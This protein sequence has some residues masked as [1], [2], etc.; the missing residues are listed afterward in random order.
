MWQRLGRDR[1]VASSRI[2]IPLL[3]QVITALSAST[4]VVDLFSGTS[5]VGHALKSDG[6]LVHANDLNAYAATIARAYVREDHLAQTTDH[7]QTINGLQGRPGYFTETFRERSRFFMP[8][9]GARIDA[10]RDWIADGAFEPE[11]EAILL[12]ALME[13]ADR[14][15]STTGVQMASLK[16]WAMD[17]DHLVVSFN[18]EGH[19]S[20]DEMVELLSSRGEVFVLERDHKRS[21]GAQI[22]IHAPTSERVGAVSHLRNT[23]LV[24]V[25]PR[26]PDDFQ[27]PSNP[28]GE[29]STGPRAGL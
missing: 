21:V 5:R 13:V 4:S 23:A 25:V 14:V 2:L 26:H 8:K 15:D 6:Y 10:M 27:L 24:F 17:V 20:K 3:R 29:P 18:N 11:L 16:S 9:N 19:I 1:L 7:I 22:G 12:V 28:V